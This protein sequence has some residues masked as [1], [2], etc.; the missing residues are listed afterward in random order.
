MSCVNLCWASNKYVPHETLT[1]TVLKIVVNGAVQPVGRRLL[2]ATHG[3]TL[4]GIRLCRWREAEFM[5][6]QSENSQAP[7]ARPIRSR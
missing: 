7:A 3:K 4:S 1:S 6:P 5:S 2:L